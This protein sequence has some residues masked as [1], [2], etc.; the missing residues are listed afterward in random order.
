VALN[1]V[2]FAKK[3]DGRDGDEGSAVIRSELGLE[4]PADFRLE[5]DEA[6]R[7][8]RQIR[9]PAIAAAKQAHAACEFGTGFPCPAPG[10]EGNR[11]VNVCIQRADGTVSC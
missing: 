8:A 1:W 11:S 9:W 7:C 10:R 5:P 2:R 3:I 4:G 6:L